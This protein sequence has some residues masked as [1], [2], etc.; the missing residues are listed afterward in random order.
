MAGI[1]ILANI[2]LV[3][4]TITFQYLGTKKTMDA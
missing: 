3:F 2:F 1:F 4:K